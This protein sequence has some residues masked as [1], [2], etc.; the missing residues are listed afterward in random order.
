MSTSFKGTAKRID[1]IDLPRLGAQLGVGEDELHAFIEAETRGSGF[2][3][4]GRPRI[5]FER[6]K[7]YKYLPASKRD[8][9]VK[10][11]LASPK[12]GGY[13]KESTQY[14]KL[15]RAIAI[16]RK[17][18]LYACSWG[19]AQ[20]MGFNHKL[21]GYD[22]VEEMVAAFMEDEENH[23]AAAVQFIQNTKLDDELR[24]HDWAG[25]AKGYNGPDYRINRYDEKLAEA[26]AKWKRIKDTPW[27][28]AV[29][30]DT[31]AVVVPAPKEGEAI[32]V[33]T[34]NLD[35]PPA[36][37]AIPTSKKGLAVLFSIIAALFAG[38]VKYFGG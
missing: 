29:P 28:P 22:D 33:V 27:S 16:D 35:N 2:D 11:G 26:Y 32:V 4:Q 24:R 13:G 7:F 31:P 23:L 15:E 36:A 14:A 1:D 30:A 9:A 18:A 25:F 12:A 21:A 17:A 6:H 3:D 38:V 34:P 5:L 20:I 37:P 8:A 19:L 10:A